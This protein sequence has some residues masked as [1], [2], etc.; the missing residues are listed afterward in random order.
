V[1]F[2]S[3]LVGLISLAIAAPV[4]LFLRACFECANADTDAPAAWLAW[5]GAARLLYGF[6]AHKRWHYTR[7]GGQ[8]RHLV[9]WYIRCAGEP[10]I[11]TLLDLC[12]AARCALTGATP[13]WRAAARAAADPQLW[14]VRGCPQLWLDDRQ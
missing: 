9:R 2:D 5:G 3:L 12:H 1:P 7:G 11:A 8:P 6:S 4:T 10:A 13:C 14:R